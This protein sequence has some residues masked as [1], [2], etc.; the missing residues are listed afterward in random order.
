MNIA[1]LT[2]SIRM[3]DQIKYWKELSDYDI[4][5]AHV[6]L[7]SKRYLYVGFMAHQSIE[8]MLKAYFVQ[9]NGKSAPFSHSL[10]FI[11]KKAKL[12]ELFSDD[13]KNFIDMLEPLNIECRYP[14]HKEQL[15]KSLTIERCNEILHK[16][17]ELQLWINQK[18]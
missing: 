8:K 14:S 16:A 12:Y 18:L 17:E 1:N 13:Q 4:Q 15:M 5:T 6:M 10:S 7:K 3:L 9:S 2:W 11:A